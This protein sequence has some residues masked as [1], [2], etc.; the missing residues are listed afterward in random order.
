MI[1]RTHQ[2][3]T[4]TDRQ[5]LREMAAVCSS[6]RPI[7]RAM[8]RT[9][10]AVGWQRRFLRI[11]LANSSEEAMANRNKWSGAERPAAQIERLNVSSE[12]NDRVERL[13]RLA[14]CA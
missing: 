1:R 4:E 10:T 12:H 5:Q 11:R 8:G 6:D 9:V 13:M 2:K 14:G 3:W 7:A